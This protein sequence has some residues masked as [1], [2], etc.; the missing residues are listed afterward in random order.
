MQT[1]D[2]VVSQLSNCKYFS[3]LDQRSGYWQVQMDDQSA[4][5]CMFITQ[6]DRYQYIRF[7][8]GLAS[9][10]DIFQNQSDQTFS[11]IPNVYCIT[12]D[13]LIAAPN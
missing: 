10:P 8:M 5:I 4:D 13:I 1:F 3:L 12:D 11:D 9:A 7:P 6:H 2:E